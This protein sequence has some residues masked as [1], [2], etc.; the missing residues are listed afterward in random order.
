[1]FLFDFVEGLGCVFNFEFDFE[2]EL[3]Q[4]KVYSFLGKVEKEVSYVL[5]RPKR[6]WGPVQQMWAEGSE[7]YQCPSIRLFLSIV[8]TLNINDIQ[9]MYFVS[10]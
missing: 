3:T 6:T 2:Y 9:D 1:M 8:E 5:D 4:L 10:V 7:K